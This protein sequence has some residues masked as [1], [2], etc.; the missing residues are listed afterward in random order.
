M[1]CYPTA[2]DTFQLEPLEDW[3]AHGTIRDITQYT[4]RTS[5]EISRPPLFKTLSF[6]HAESEAFMNKEYLSLY[7]KTYG[8]VDQRFLYDGGDY[9]IDSPF[10]NLLFENLNQSGLMVGYCLTPAPDFKP[11][12]PKPIFLYYNGGAS[13]SFYFD[14]DTTVDNITNYAVFGAEL[15]YQGQTWSLNYSVE[16]SVKNDATLYNSLYQVYYSGYLNNLYNTKTRVVR[17]KAIFPIGLC[18]KLKLNDRLIIRD[19]RYIINEIEFN[20]S[21]GEVDLELINDFRAVVNY[22]PMKP[23]KSAQ[24]VTVPMYVKNAVA[25]VNFSSSNGSVA[26]SNNNIT[27]DQNIDV[28]IPSNADE[29]F[30]YITEDGYQEITEDFKAERS[31]SGTDQIIDIIMTEYSSEDDTTNVETIYI[32]QQS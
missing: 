14:N 12:I 5:I 4:D 26:F 9:T 28:S 1:T 6:K 20:L 13:C 32:Q 8:D 22:H 7:K 18:Y 21:T 2:L 27:F 23:T 29:G 15:N 3:Y 11:Y 16:Q 17:C 24:L 10:E 25:Y 19:K 30:M 31:E